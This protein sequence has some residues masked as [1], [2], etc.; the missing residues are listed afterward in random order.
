MLLNYKI[1][2]TKQSRYYFIEE[3]NNIIYRLIYYFTELLR[4]YFIE[5]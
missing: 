2:F 3:Y 5:E 4:Y 1:L